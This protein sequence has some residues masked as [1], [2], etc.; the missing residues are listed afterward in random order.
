[1]LQQLLYVS[2]AQGRLTPEDVASILASSRRNNARSGI[3][4]LLL[5]N[6]GVFIQYLEGDRTDIARLIERLKRDPRHRNV[7]VMMERESRDRVFGAWHMGFK[8]LDVTVAR[9]AQVFRLSRAAIEARTAGSEAA[10]ILDTILAFA[11][12]DA[13]ACA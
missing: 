5:F 8:T 7:M 12:D 13:L 3:T 4:G 11:G 6:D 10:L 2:G 1:M 9:E